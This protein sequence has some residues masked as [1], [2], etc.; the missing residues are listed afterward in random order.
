M[1]IAATLIRLAARPEGVCS[2]DVP[3]TSRQ[4]ALTV[5]MRLVGRGELF[6]ARITR[7]E[8]RFY[9]RIGAAASAERE[10]SMPSVQ[11][12]PVKA[13][14]AAEVITPEGV[15]FTICPTPPQRFTALDEFHP[16]LKHRA[17]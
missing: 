12:A 3:G 4:V 9:T 11:V 8:S 7:R 2:S 1:T 13:L 17:R 6:L 10:H 14:T 15:K 5:A 16:L